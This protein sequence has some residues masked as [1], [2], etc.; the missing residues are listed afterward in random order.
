MA[1][2]VCLYGV[3]T[4]VCLIFGYLESLVSFSF[5]APGIKLGLANTV[6]LILAFNKDCKGAYLV[7]II[8]II[9]SALLFS[10]PFA[11]VF[12]M[13]AGILSVTVCCLLSKIN[14]VSAV[15]VAVIGAV[16]HNVTQLAVAF[17]IFGGG[18]WYYL[19]P[20][21]ISGAVGG[22]VIGFICNIIL[23]KIKTNLKI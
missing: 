3:F 12:S 17:V 8:R 15:G 13:P 16:T 11:L 2:R 21:L 19:P 20:L 4:A 6:P 22:G 23:K 7:N 10:A 9:I 5:I 18:V 14:S 1:K